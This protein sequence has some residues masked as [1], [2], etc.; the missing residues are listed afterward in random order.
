LNEPA[1]IGEVENILSKKIKKMMEEAL[2]YAKEKQTDLARLGEHFW[3]QYPKEYFQLRE[4]WN[5]KI[6]PEVDVDIKVKSILRRTDMK[7]EPFFIKD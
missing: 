3:L 1:I 2:E 6:L 4:D 5:E 7:F